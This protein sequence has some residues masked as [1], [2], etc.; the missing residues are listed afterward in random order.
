[1]ESDDM[2]PYGT[3][4]KGHSMH[5]HNT[6]GICSGHPPL[7]SSSA[8][9]YEKQQTYKEVYEYLSYDTLHEEECEV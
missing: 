8:R 4:K 2:K 7:N 6:C 5:P 3:H 1:M 9:A